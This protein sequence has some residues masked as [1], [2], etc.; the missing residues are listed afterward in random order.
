ME[1]CPFH[2]TIYLD[3]QEQF[4][5]HSD[6]YETSQM[7]NVSWFVL[8]PVMEWYFKKKDSRYRALP[9]FAPGCELLD[10]APME[11]IYPRETRQVFIP[12]GL[13]G[14]LSRVVFEA[15]HRE[16]GATIH[17]HLDE[18]YLGET[19]MIH[20]LEFNAPVGMHTLTLVDSNGNFLEKRFEVVEN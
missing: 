20:Q 10:E 7:M 8:P 17:W 3:A 18:Q 12:R 11:L 19:S 14:Q 1:S 13:D 2:R 15:A 9:P 5:V 6:C 4:R 16:A